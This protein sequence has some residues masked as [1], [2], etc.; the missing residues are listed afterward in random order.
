MDDWHIDI[1]AQTAEHPNG[2]KLAF[3]GRP[4]TRHFSG[5]PVNVPKGLAALEV[6]RMIREGYEAY[7]KAFPDAPPPPRQPQSA[8]G[9]DGPRVTVRR[10]RPRRRLQE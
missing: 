5:N 6:V 10:R 7:E 4:Q 1:D 3:E 2:F 9:E 8:D